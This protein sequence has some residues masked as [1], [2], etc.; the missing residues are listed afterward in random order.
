LVQEANG[1]VPVTCTSLP[2]LV[3]CPVDENPIAQTAA[4]RLPL[5]S[6]RKNKRVVRFIILLSLGSSVSMY[7][8]KLRASLVHPFAEDRASDH[9]G[10]G[11]GSAIILL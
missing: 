10:L 1:S 11:G 6:W 8:L 9:D 3:A 4:T 7:R 2:R 5:A